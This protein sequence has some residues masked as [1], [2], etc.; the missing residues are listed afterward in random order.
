MQQHFSETDIA[1]LK[2]QVEETERAF[3]ATMAQRDHAAFVDFL[4]EEAIFFSA[5]KPTRGKANI[6]ALWK[7]FFEAE[8]APFSWEPQVV[9]VLDTGDLALSSGPVYTPDGQ[10][11][12]RFNSIWVQK[13]KGQWKVVFDKGDE[14]CD[15][16]L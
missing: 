3:A 6:A 8:K 10:E 11:V 9:E 1:L 13:A 16:S 5:C 14:P 12:G 15:P 7:P 4:A 2:Q